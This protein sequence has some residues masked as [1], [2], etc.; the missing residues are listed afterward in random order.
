M[1][2]A[3]RSSVSLLT[4]ASRNKMRLQERSARSHVELPAE[5]LLGTTESAFPPSSKAPTPRQHEP[6]PSRI[7]RSSRFTPSLLRRFVG[8]PFVHAEDFR[9]PIGVLLDVFDN[10]L[11]AKHL[12]EWVAFEN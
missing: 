2:I 10:F 6:N 7:V 5:R 9:T 12:L 1:I 4:C 8:E 3:A 11:A